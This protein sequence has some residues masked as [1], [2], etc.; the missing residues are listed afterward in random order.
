ME[1]SEQEE[2]IESSKLQPTRWYRNVD[3]TFA[4]RSHRRETSDDFLQ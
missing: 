1:A 2:A 4:I 3:N